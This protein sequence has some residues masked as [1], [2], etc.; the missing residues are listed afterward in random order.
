MQLI[1]SNTWFED[2]DLLAEQNRRPAGGL[3]NKLL[4]TR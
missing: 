3:F 4:E 1:G 2:L